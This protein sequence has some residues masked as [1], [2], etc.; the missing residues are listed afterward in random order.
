MMSL[1]G[2]EPKIAMGRAFSNKQIISYRPA[3]KASNKQA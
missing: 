1:E 2:Q 3:I